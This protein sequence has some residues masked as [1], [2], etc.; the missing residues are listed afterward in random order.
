MIFWLWSFD[1][2]FRQLLHLCSTPLGSSKLSPPVP[3][4]NQPNIDTRVTL[5]VLTDFP[6]RSTSKITFPNSVKHTTFFMA[7]TNTNEHVSFESWWKKELLPEWFSVKFV[8]LP[9]WSIALAK[10]FAC[11]PVCMSAIAQVLPTRLHHMLL[12]FQTTTL[13]KHELFETI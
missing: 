12:W 6:F 5:G 4:R 1:V 2:N 8:M 9:V 13:V 10:W 7:D 3:F 11:M